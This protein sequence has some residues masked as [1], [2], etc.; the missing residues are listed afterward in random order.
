VDLKPFSA[1]SAGDVEGFTLFPCAL[2]VRLPA[3]ALQHLG[4]Q[5]EFYR[6]TSS[7]VLHSEKRLAFVEALA[8]AGYAQ[9]GLN[10]SPPPVSLPRSAGARHSASVFVTQKEMLSQFTGD[11]A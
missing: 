2:S 8:Q 9:A 4:R 6:S 3:G 5:I 7:F 1:S 10:L 11:L